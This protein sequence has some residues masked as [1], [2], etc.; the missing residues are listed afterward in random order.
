MVFPPCPV[1]PLSPH[2]GAPDSRD[3]PPIPWRV[4]CHRRSPAHHRP[5]REQERAPY[6]LLAD[7]STPEALQR[8]MA[9]QDGR[10]GIVSAESELFLMAS[11]RYSDRGPSLQVYLSGF[12]GEPM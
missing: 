9:Q 5:A 3:V 8:Q 11:G 4:R 6:A 10:V 7:D 1:D 2:S 12:S